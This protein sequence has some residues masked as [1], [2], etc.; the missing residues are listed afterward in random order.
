MFKISH[1]DILKFNFFLFCSFRTKNL[2]KMPILLITSKLKLRRF[3]NNIILESG[4]KLT[5]QK[6]FCT[7]RGKVRE[8]Q[9][10]IHLSEKF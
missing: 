4:V 10:L 1:L 7:K 8:N 9:S 5:L 6:I 3:M 2:N